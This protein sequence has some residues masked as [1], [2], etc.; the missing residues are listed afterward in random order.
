MRCDPLYGKGRGPG[1]TSVAAATAVRCAEL[2]AADPGHQ[3][4]CRPQPRDSLDFPLGE[5]PK[6]VA[7]NLWAQEVN[8]LHQLESPLGP[9]PHLPSARCFSSQGALTTSW[10][11]SWPRRRDGGDRLPDADPP[12]QG[13]RASTNT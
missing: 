8:A 6:K 5:D 10:P 7:T 4:R 1:K 2:R 13:K 3:H 9:D 12:A 11:R